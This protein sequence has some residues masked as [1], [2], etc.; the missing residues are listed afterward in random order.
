MSLKIFHII[1]IVASFRQGDDVIPLF[2]KKERKAFNPAC[3]LPSPYGPVYY[4]PVF[5]L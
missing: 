3:T 5:M 2:L 1:H 4:C